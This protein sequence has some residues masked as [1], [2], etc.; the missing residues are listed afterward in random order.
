LGPLAT[1]ILGDLG[2]DVIKIEPREGDIARAAGVAR[3]PGMGSLHLAVNRNKRSIVLDLKQPAGAAVLR[4]LLAR[5]DVL[6]HNMRAQ[7][8]ARLGFDYDA[9]KAVK[10]DIVYCAAYGFG[11]TGPYRD[12][13]AYD[14]LIQA[15][16]GIA[17]LGGVNNDAPRYAPTLIADK[18]VGMTALYAVLA[19]LYHRAK[20]GQGQAVE[21]PMF[22]TMVA[23]TLAEHLGGLT[24]EPAEGP[25]G[26]GRVLAPDRR[27]H[28]TTDGHVA[29]LPYTSRHWRD[30]FALAGRP[31]LADDPRFVD[32]P[33]R[34]RNIAALYALLAELVA[35]H[36]S[37]YWLD[38]CMQADI[39]CAPVNPLDALPDDEHLKAVGLFT[40]TDHP[41]EGRIRELRPPV[42]FA[43]TPTTIR[44]PAPR[45]GADT[46]A[47]LREHGYAD[48][49]ISALAKDGAIVLGDD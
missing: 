13:P 41:T 48:D 7:A 46:A 11:A 26:Y 47:V 44:R 36:S 30:F 10:P 22:E 33:A 37:A 15:R 21:V 28:R 9:V 18:T 43:A 25:A 8:I 23:F 16:A 38:R 24:F 14:D 29:L 20:T 6:V 1:Q 4:R 12:H 35:T 27:P 40:T 3:H 2:A 45:L 49:E 34:N 19:A 5:A 39:P 32:P 42:N 31:D 17:A